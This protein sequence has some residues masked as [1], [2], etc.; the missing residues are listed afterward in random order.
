MKKGI[1]AIFWAAVVLVTMAVMLA[2][3]AEAK[4]NK[5]KGQGSFTTPTV[6]AEQALATVKAA[7]PRLTA[8]KAFVKT[9]KRGERN[10]EVALVLEGNIVAK[11]RLNPATGEILPKGHKVQATQVLASRE[12]AVTIVQ[13]AIPNLEVASV[14]LGKQGEWKVDLTLKKAVVASIKVHGGDGSILPDWKASR[15]A[16][17]F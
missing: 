2:T 15:D 8:G 13:Q 5:D 3:P 10:L 6:T 12:Q 17:M 7:L 14:Q 1:W 9:G 11:I 4:K 16:R